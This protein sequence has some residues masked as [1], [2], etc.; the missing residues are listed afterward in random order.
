MGAAVKILLTAA[1]VVP[2]A[3]ALLRDAGVVIDAGKIVDV[4]RASDLRSRHPDAS[5]IDLGNAAILPGLI[6]AHVHLE[7][8]DC[9]CGPSP[10]GSFTDWIQSIP[11]KRNIPGAARSAAVAEA[12]QMGIDQCLRF[13]VTCAGDIS[14]HSHLTRPVLRDS[15][16][17][18]ISFGEM[19][20]L[21]KGRPRFD[22]L[23]NRALDDSCATD[24][25]KIGLSPHAPYTVEPSNYRRSVEAARAR[26]WAITSHIAE[27]PEE[28]RFIR[29]ASGSFRDLWEKLG[30]W[31]DSTERF[32]GTPIQ[33]AAAVGLIGAPRSL[34]AHVNYCSD[35]DLALLARGRASVVFCPRTHAYFR[36]P[37]HRW[38]DMLAAGVN[39]C[40]GTDSCASS[41]DLN[42]VDDLR[43]LHHQSP[44]VPAQTLWELITT[45]PADALGR[46]DLGRLAPG[47]AADLAIF[48]IAPAADD[49]LAHLLETPAL[50]SQTWIAGQRVH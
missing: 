29:H 39:V 37:P 10:G 44:D 48:P 11:L 32:D 4:G 21:A 31:D 15:P 17:R 34:L 8:S 50:P 36:H 40:V 6:N 47:A 25:L 7:L 43:L 45:R 2:I 35:A 23:L 41:P 16:L 33:L 28:E 19:L 26:G 30:Q 18:A 12:A 9:Q 38:R 13:G 20:G 27:T 46:A 3:R 24:R 22:D 42:L 14:Q 5:L 49:P 1:V